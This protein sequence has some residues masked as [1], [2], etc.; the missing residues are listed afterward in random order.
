M[1]TKITFEEAVVDV[2]EKYDQGV[3]EG[4]D[5]DVLTHQ[6][7]EEIRQALEAV[8]DGDLLL[9]ELPPDDEPDNRSKRSKRQRRLQNVERA[10]ATL[11]ERAQVGHAVPTYAFRTSGESHTPKIACVCRC[12]DITRTA[13]GQSKQEAKRKAAR[14]V[15]EAVLE[16]ELD[17]T[18]KEV[19]GVDDK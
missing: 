3:D 8:C 6:C 15:L 12:G 19:V 1:D 5:I 2:F 16:A 17:A 11:N 4:V 14:L 18:F 10:V 13:V 7:L 9:S